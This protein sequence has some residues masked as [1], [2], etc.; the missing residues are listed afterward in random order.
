MGDQ[1]TEGAVNDVKGNA[2]ETA[3]K[4]SGNEEQQIQ[5]KTEQVQGAAQKTLGKAQDKAQD[6]VE[7]L[8]R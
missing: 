4:L 5:G 8:K 1:Q 3:G 6:A 7:N 2:E